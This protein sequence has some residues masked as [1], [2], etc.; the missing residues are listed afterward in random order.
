MDVQ[1]GNFSTKFPSEFLQ[2]LKPS[3]HLLEEP[4]KL[5]EQLESQGY[6]VLENYKLKNFNNCVLGIST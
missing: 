2:P 6:M 3:N 1:L 4:V 5:K